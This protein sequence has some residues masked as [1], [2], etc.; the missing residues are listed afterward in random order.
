MTERI[1]ILRIVNGGLPFGGGPD[2][3][4]QEVLGKE[5][6]LHVE[7]RRGNRAR[8][9]PSRQTVYRARPGANARLALFAGSVVAGPAPCPA[10][11]T[12]S[13]PANRS[14]I[15]VGE[16]ER[17]VG[18]WCRWRLPSTYRRKNVTPHPFHRRART[19]SFVSP[20]P[21]AG[22]VSTAGRAGVFLNNAV[23]VGDR[24]SSL[25]FARDDMEKGAW[26]DIL[27]GMLEV[28]VCGGV[29]LLV[30]WVR[31]RSPERRPGV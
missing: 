9:P 7:S 6:A 31:D 12:G 4:C 3:V 22:P 14:P 26:D 19:P 2:A 8:R 21:D 11:G 1:E 28:K 23:T 17:A 13:S 10:V 30:R 5:L 16:D 27:G 24:L 25:G 15:G 20:H 18:P 29:A